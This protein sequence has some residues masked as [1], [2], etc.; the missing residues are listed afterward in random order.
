MK[1]FALFAALLSFV[2]SGCDQ[3]KES[4]NNNG[5]TTQASLANAS[6]TVIKVPTVQCNSCASKV[7]KALQGLAGV[8]SAKV[9]LAA[10]TVA[11]SFAADQLQLA[12]LEK[13]IAAAGYDANDT[14][15]DA[16]AYD[17][18]DACCKVPEDG[19]GH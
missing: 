16:A 12:D 3:S 7:E 11:V 2:F 17:A 6:E 9:T 19:G 10:K 18:L 4:A 1:R 14:K 15:R 13:A 8:K 5:S